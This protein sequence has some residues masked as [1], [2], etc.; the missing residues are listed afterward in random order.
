[1]VGCIGTGIALNIHPASPNILL[2]ALL[3]GPTAPPKDIRRTD[4]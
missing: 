1:M 3:N 4:V 2:N